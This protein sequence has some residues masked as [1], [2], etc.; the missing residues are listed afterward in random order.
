MGTSGFEGCSFPSLKVGF[1]KVIVGMRR[2][3]TVAKGSVSPLYATFP[4][5]SAIRYDLWSSGP[6]GSYRLIALVYLIMGTANSG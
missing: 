2:Q 6:V 1:V 5:I 4:S 3:T